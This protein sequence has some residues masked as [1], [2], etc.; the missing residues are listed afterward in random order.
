M[1]LVEL[2]EA[3]AYA[4]GHG[5]DL[6]GLLSEADRFVALLPA[7]TGNLRQ[8]RALA[9]LI[10]H[11]D[12]DDWHELERHARAAFAAPAGEPHPVERFLWVLSGHLLG[13]LQDIRAG[14]YRLRGVGPNG[15]EIDLD[16]EWFADDRVILHFLDNAATA[17]DGRRFPW[18]AGHRTRP[19]LA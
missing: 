10:D 5:R 17:P 12:D 2:F 13:L 18:V 8:W 4:S 14:H 19:I 16:P 11:W 9:W 6:P 15:T 1:S 3:R 7:P